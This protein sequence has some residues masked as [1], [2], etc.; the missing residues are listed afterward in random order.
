MNNDMQNQSFEEQSRHAREATARLKKRMIIVLIGLVVFAVVAIPLIGVLEKALGE[1]NEA[2]TAAPP[3]SSVIFATPDYDYD[4]MKD[5]D[6]LAKDRRIYYYDER[7]GEMQVLD[8]KNFN[9]FG[10][11]TVVLKTMIECIIAGDAEGYNALF[12]ENYFANHTPEDAFTMQ[13]LYDIKLTKVA[14][15]E[16]TPER[17]KSYTQYEF[18]VE[19]KIRWNNGTFRT[20]IGHD[21]SKKQYFVLSDST[22]SEVLIDQILNYNYS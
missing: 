2:V 17:G 3:P 5:A 7:S 8:D 12:S 10:P 1:G 19:Y 15:S 14:Q 13:Q 21:E 16:I 4:I 6:Y 11:A 22:S 9:N 20:D 18:E